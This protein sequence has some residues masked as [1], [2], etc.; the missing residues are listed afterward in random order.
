MRTKNHADCGPHSGPYKMTDAANPFADLPASE[1][2]EEESAEQAELRELQHYVNRVLSRAFIYSII[3]VFGIGS[4]YS[5]YLAWKAHRII[6]ESN[7]R[8]EG[9]LGVWWCYL[10]AGFGVLL[11]TGGLAMIIYNSQQV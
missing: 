1:S 6:R 7:G 4:F 5:F 11:F 2:G 10:F 8:I 3:W 9:L